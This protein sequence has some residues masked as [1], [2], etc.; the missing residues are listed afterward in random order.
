MGE[1]GIGTEAEGER[2]RGREMKVK[3][4]GETKRD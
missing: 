3:K 4:Q 2:G 1:R